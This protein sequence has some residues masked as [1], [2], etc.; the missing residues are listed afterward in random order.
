MK[1][2]KINTQLEMTVTQQIHP[3]RVHFESIL[4]KRI[5]DSYWFRVKK[6]MQQNKCFNKSGVS[7]YLNRKTPNPSDIENTTKWL[8]SAPDKIKF[9]NF[10]QIIEKVFNIKWSK[11]PGRTT[12]YSW[13]HRANLKRDKESRCRKH[14]LYTKSELIPV[15]TLILNSR[16]IKTYN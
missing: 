11:K 5:S 9:V 16:L 15:V 12:I 1:L 6:W 10:L 3:V 14:F 13:F 4:G 8:E 2:S 7:L